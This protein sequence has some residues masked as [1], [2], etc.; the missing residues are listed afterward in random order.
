VADEPAAAPNDAET[1]EAREPV[2]RERE[3][4]RATPWS[5]AQIIGLIVGI[6]FVVFG[7]AAVNN[8]GAP[9]LYTPQATVWHLGYSP[10]LGW[11]TIAFGGL[12]VLASILPG[13]ARAVMTLFGAI[14][15]ALGIVIVVDAA[16][17][18]LHHWLGVTH[19]NGWV[20]IVVGAVLLL[21]AFASP[22]FYGTHRRERMEPIR[23]VRG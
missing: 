3:S 10:L 22:V 19:T 14:A 18:R 13:M 23:V 2:V 5:P 8:T 9:H 1:V 15:L 21:A 6:G 11:S 16:P 20:Y 4:Y 12:L 7:I 17:T